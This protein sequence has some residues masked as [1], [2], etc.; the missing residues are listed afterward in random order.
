MAAQA[1]GLITYMHIEKTFMVYKQSV[2]IL[3]AE[4]TIHELELGLNFLTKHLDTVW[5]TLFMCP[6]DQKICCGIYINL[7]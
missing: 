1:H 4:T 2:F 5:H 7:L 6:L 3:H